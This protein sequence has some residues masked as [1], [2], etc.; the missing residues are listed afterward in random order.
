MAPRRRYRCVANIKELSQVLENNETVNPGTL[1]LF[2]SPI[3]PNVSRNSFTQP[4]GRRVGDARHGRAL[5][6]GCSR[7]LRCSDALSLP[8][9][10]APHRNPQ[11]PRSPAGDAQRRQRTVTNATLVHGVHAE[12]TV[13]CILIPA[14]A[15]CLL[16]FVVNSVCPFVTL[17]QISSFLFVDSS[18]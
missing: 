12:R 17:L 7:C 11:P 6:D 9:T 3:L 8:T 2:P 16:F 10:T 13:N 15:R 1:I 5:R 18:V 4:A 14:L